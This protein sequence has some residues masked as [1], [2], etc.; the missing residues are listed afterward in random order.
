LQQAAAALGD[1]TEIWT[2]TARRVTERPTTLAEGRA[3]LTA[4]GPPVLLVFGTGWGLAPEVHF[5][6]ARHLQPVVPPRSRGY[7]HLSVRAAAAIIFDRLLG[8]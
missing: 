1:D 2:T 6:A 4:D 5:Q 7:N 3:L 8:A